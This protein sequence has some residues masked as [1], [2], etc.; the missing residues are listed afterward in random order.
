MYLAYL[1]T[2]VVGSIGGPCLCGLNV[3][4]CK[5]L[6]RYMVARCELCAVCKLVQHLGKFIE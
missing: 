6:H 2:S 4:V 5:L 1:A 3:F